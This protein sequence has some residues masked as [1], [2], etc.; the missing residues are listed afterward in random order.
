[1]TSQ[2]IAAAGPAEG[3]RRAVRENAAVVAVMALYVGVCF[4]VARVGGAPFSLKLYGL[5]WLIMAVAVA[6]VAVARPVTPK[7]W[8]LAERLTVAAPVLVMAPAFF[9]AFTSLKSGLTRLHPYTWDPVVAGWDRAL[10]GGHDAWAVLQPVL[11]HPPIT[12][13]L[14]V[15]YS[16]W[17]P[18]MI[19]VFGGL[20]LSLGRP[21]LRAQALLAMVAC[22]ALLGTWAA[23]AL[24][25]A[26]PC[27]IGPL[28][29]GIDAFAPQAAYLRAANQQL[30]I[31]EFAEQNRLLAAAAS[32]RPVLGSGISAMPSMHIAVATLMMLVGWRISRPA[33]IAG[34]VYLAIV[35]VASIHLG[36]HYAMDGVAGALG[37]WGLWLIAGEVARRAIARRD[38]GGARPS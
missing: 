12:F 18:A 34:S 28:H 29:L 26:G 14:S 13:A 22:W 5:L 38:G 1:M 21:Q 32:G 11:G 37:A 36:W 3:L 7:G 35:V 15:L 31:W 23:T 24:A 2:A 30:P 6:M 17:H 8:R 27:F 9:S 20:T 10:F 33:G 4:G 25:S 16:A 19:T